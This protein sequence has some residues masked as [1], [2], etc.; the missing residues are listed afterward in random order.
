MKSPLLRLLCPEE[1][2]DQ[3]GDDTREEWGKRGFGTCFFLEDKCGVC[4]CGKC[5][6]LRGLLASG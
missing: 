3:M 1:E 2:E 4:V 6:K 5:E